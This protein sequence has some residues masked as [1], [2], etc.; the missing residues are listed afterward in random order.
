MPL[1]MIWIFGFEIVLTELWHF[2]CFSFYSYNIFP[3]IEMYIIVII[4]SSFL[5]TS[6]IRL[7]SDVSLAR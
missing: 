5:H 4:Q 7:S 3:K 2:F 1:S 6:I